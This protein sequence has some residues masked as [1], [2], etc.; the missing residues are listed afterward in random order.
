MIMKMVIKKEK[1][2]TLMKIK[3]VEKS[4]RNVEEVGD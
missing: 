3:S 2:I 4:F 1:E